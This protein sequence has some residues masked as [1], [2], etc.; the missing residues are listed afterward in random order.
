MSE[1]Q[2]C[3]IISVQFKIKKPKNHIA[4]GLHGVQG[5]TDFLRWSISSFNMIGMIVNFNEI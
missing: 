3:I 5:I 4:L 1:C 2:S